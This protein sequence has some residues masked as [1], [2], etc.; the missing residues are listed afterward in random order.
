[1]PDAATKELL[2]P[3]LPDA[4]TKELLKPRLTGTAKQEL[5]GARLSDTATK[6]LLEPQLSSLTALL[7][8]S[9]SSQN[10]NNKLQEMRSK[11]S[12]KIYSLEA[13]QKDE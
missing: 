7:R 11:F 2:E 9:V 3:R 6:D 10:S 13:D 4:A 12:E 1:M 8:Q 5:L